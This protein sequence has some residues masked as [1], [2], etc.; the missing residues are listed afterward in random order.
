M[1]S[2]EEMFKQEYAKLIMNWE[3]LFLQNPSVLK[4]AVSAMDIYGRLKWD[5]AQHDAAKR[6]RERKDKK[7]PMMPGFPIS[8]TPYKP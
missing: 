5:E 3:D 6:S 7:F 1:K 4:A 2:K 8:I